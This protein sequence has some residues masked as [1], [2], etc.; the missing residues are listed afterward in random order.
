MP[1]ASSTSVVVAARRTLSQIAVQ[2]TIYR[3]G[4][5]KPYCLRI[6]WPSA[7][8]RKPRN[9]RAASTSAAPLR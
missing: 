9:A 6:A 4:R 2:S 3:S 8:R 5:E 1:I 7:L